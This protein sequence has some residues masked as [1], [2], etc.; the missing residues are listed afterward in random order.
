MKLFNSG[1]VTPDPIEFTTNLDLRNAIGEYLSQGCPNGATCEY[2]GAIG[3]WD[4]SRVQDF[5]SLF[6][7]PMGNGSP[8]PE[9][10]AFNQPINWNTGL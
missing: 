2:D 7:E 9:A 1:P 5:T 4:V 3:D 8:F 10:A 6:Q